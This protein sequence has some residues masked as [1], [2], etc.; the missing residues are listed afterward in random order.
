[1]KININ[2]KVTIKIPKSQNKTGI[3]VAKLNAIQNVSDADKSILDEVVA[4]LFKQPDIKPEEHVWPEFGNPFR[5]K[6][7]P[8]LL[9]GHCSKSIMM[10]VLAATIVTSLKD[11]E[12]V[13]TAEDWHALVEN[14]NSKL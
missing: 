12:S 13:V 3:D 6:A 14:V 11:E 8:G 5:S 1:M 4:S 7:K 2:T 9:S 10:D